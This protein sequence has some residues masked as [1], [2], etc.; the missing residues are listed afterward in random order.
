MS[1]ADLSEVLPEVPEIEEA[2]DI[3]GTGVLT[4]GVVPASPRAASVDP[5]EL[6][7]SIP[8]DIEEPGE[9]LQDRNG[10]RVD[11]TRASQGMTTPRRVT[12]DPTININ[13]QNEDRRVP[14]SED[15]RQ[16]LL[17]RLTR[18][19]LGEADTGI[20][21]PR[22]TPSTLSRYQ[23]RTT[24]GPLGTHRATMGLDHHR[25]SLGTPRGY[26]YDSYRTGN[27]AKLK[28]PPIF[29]GTYSEFN[30]ILNWIITVERYLF[31]CD[32]TEELYPTY[33]YTYMTET[34]QAWYD[35][36]F[37]VDKLPKWDTVVEA[38]KKRYLP[39]NH[40][41]RLLRKFE[42]TRQARSLL[43]YVDEFQIVVS[44]LQLV[45]IHKSEEELV[46]HF[47]DGLRNFED[48]MN[49]L[50]QGVQ[51]LDRCYEM[52][53]LIQGAR[54]VAGPPTGTDKDRRKLNKLTGSAKK[55]A[56]KK[57]LCLSCGKSGHWWRECPNEKKLLKYLEKRTGKTGTR[58]KAPSKTVPKRNFKL[59]A[60]AG[61]PDEDKGAGGTSEEEENEAESEIT[62]E[63][64]DESGNE[65]SRSSSAGGNSDED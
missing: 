28:Q 50:T 39:T 34:V 19:L 15:E 31:N 10:A 8:T 65:T 17:E 16:E 42:Q 53:T 52:A 35:N 49:M 21:A 37:L 57:D 13:I 36:Y 30:N 45:D 23:R 63:D 64:D 61:A 27:R 33:A 60:A 24:F 58:N 44:A 38:L 7:R 22:L 62:T 43:G 5:R 9:F 18:L 54:A 55:E 4:S 1:H 11:H 46:R 51:T 3:Q 14:T 41:P 2:T 20:Q 32:V 26:A 29:K 47:I 6:I 12:M 25:S 59:Q 56:F 40:V 48:R